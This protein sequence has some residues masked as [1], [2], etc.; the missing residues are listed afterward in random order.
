MK[1]LTDIDEGTIRRVDWQELVPPVIFF[2]AFPT[3]F[4][5]SYLLLGSLLASVFVASLGFRALPPTFDP[6]NESPAFTATDSLGACFAPELRRYVPYATVFHIKVP[7]EASPFF[8]AIVCLGVVVA[9]WFALAL[10]RSAVTELARAARTSILSSSA[11]A[12][13]KFRSIIFPCALP[14][15]IFL[16]CYL[17]AIVAV[18]LGAFFAPIVSL[19][20]VLAT[21]LIA[22][23]VAAVPLAIT[24]V[25]AENTDCF[26]AV[27]RGA[28]YLTQRFLF[29]VIYAFFSLVLIGLGAAIVEFVAEICSIVWSQIYYARETRESLTWTEFWLLPILL[30]PVTYCCTSAVVYANAIYILLRR[31]VDGVPFDS[32]RMDL[33]ARKP[34]RLREILKDEKGAPQL[35]D[36]PSQGEK[37]DAN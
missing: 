10:S 37:V 12:F 14:I 20:I 23:T 32:C 15:A 1:Q 34:L 6:C 27:S 7:S 25:A 30:L 13:K 29:F 5:L 26:D 22:I 8:L 28:S 24:A 3:T 19:A 16:A 4:R 11:F 2:R 33:S 18:K 21:F 36:A 17:G 31:S 9:A 35:D